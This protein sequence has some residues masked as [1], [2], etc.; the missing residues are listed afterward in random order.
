MVNVNFGLL[1]DLTIKEFKSK[2]AS[3]YLGVVWNFLLPICYILIYTLVFSKFMMAKL[4]Q[5]SS[6]Y[7]YSIYL[8]SGLLVWTIF[9]NSILRMQNVFIE[10]SNLIKKVYFPKIILLLAIVCSAAIELM[11]NYFLLLIIL[12]I[13]GHSLSFNYLYIILLIIFIQL[14]ALGIGLILSVCTIHFRDLSQLFSII[15]PLWFWFT[16]IVYFKDVIP[17]NFLFIIN[18]NPLYYFILLFQTVIVY[19]HMNYMYL[20]NV[21]IIAVSALGVGIL[22]YRKLIKDISDLI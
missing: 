12:L 1:K 4:P 9:N 6:S 13:V 21:L 19:G 5:M 15:L 2:Y 20:L 10:N 18:W 8:S 17:E 22:V 3:S 14:F 11:I 16:P 7:D